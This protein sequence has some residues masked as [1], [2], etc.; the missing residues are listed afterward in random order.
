MEDLKM[1]RKIITLFLSLLILTG[2]QFTNDAYFASPYE[3]L[4]DQKLIS[5]NVNYGKINAL[6]NTSESFVFFDFKNKEITKHFVKINEYSINIK[7]D[8]QEIDIHTE[9]YPNDTYYFNLSLVYE[10]DGILIE[11]ILSDNYSFGEGG[12]SLTFDVE[13]KDTIYHFDIQILGSQNYEKIMI[14]DYDS[15]H[16]LIKS[17]LVDSVLDYEMMGQYYVV[18]YTDNEGKIKRILNIDIAG[19]W[20][21]NGDF[22]EFIPLN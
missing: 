13:T 19:Q 6:E 16:E 10:S 12:G 22:H 21:E 18:A 8:A 11:E 1:H 5:L 2:C 14:Y 7:E 20:I 17:T 9:I 3:S 15:N 4:D